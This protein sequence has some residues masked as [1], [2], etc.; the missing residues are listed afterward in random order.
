MMI[1]ELLFW[2]LLF[3]IFYSY[4]FYP[5]VLWVLA[6]FTLKKNKDEESNEDWPTVALLVAAY[7]EE[8]YVD[9]K[10]QNS[11][12]LDYPADKIQFIW[13]TDGSTDATNQ[14]LEKYSRMHVLFQPE[15]MGK[16]HAMN[17]AM[18]QV[19]T[20]ISI[21][22]DGNTL[23]SK[24]TVKEIALAFRNKNVGC[25]A[26]EKRILVSERDD[27]AS[28]GE[29]WYWKYESWVKNL[30]SKVGSCVGAAG[31]LFAVRTSLFYEVPTDTL[32]DDFVISLNIA[33]KG[34]RIAYTPKA[35][36]ME[37]ASASIGEEM[38]RKIR[39]AA[40]SFQVLKRQTGLLNFIKYK[41]LSWQFISHKVFRWVVIPLAMV[42]IIPLNVFLARYS[43]NA[44]LYKV[45]GILQLSFYGIVLLGYLLKDKKVA[46]GFV[47]IPYYFFMANWAMWRG[48]FRYLQKKQSVQWERAK[49]A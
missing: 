8:D 31:E 3:F 19:T 30:D 22:S 40:G 6:L 38:K 28:A 12:E 10:V 41:L 29:G 27:A 47:F 23:L 37:K 18:K 1:W 4:L 34:Y 36:A 48:F 15:R 16:V 7:N 42:L 20:D 46:L 25:V 21:F 14:L 11:L 24:E 5:L 45:T 17:R 26:G 2:L 13:V 49:R 35:F 33:M 44:E 39:I 32:L 43:L 9:A